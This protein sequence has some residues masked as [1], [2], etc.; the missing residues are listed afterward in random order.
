MLLQQIVN[1]LASGGIYTLV[2]LGLT[3]VY[4]VLK[5][6]HIAHAGIYAL[7]AYLA[8]I[9]YKIYPNIYFAFLFAMV[10]ASLAGYI[11]QRYL[12]WPLLDKPRIVPLIASIGLFLALEELY[13]LIWG[14]YVIP[15]PRVFHWKTFS[16]GHIRF[17]GADLFVFGVSLLFLF[18]LYWLVNKTRI[19]LAMRAVADDKEVAEASGI[20]SKMTIALSFVIGS[21]LAGAAGLMVGVYYN[22]IYPTMGDVPAYKSL[23]VIVVGGMGSI[24]GTVLAGFGLGLLEALLLGYLPFAFPRDALAFIAMIAFLLIKPEG[25]FGK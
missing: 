14:P 23:A 2:A 6:L 10:G 8:L 5:I 3:L 17:P 25:I 4:G 16:V 24:E 12:Y 19:G 7:G 9:A 13:R 22:S 20:N 1:G 11:V 15:F 21:A 18:L